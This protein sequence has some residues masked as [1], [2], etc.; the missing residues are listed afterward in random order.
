MEWINIVFLPS[1]KKTDRKMKFEWK[2][3]CALWFNVLY[4]T[5]VCF[6]LALAMSPDQL[7][8]Y[9]L[10]VVIYFDTNDNL[11][12]VHILL[13]MAYPGFKKPNLWLKINMES[14]MQI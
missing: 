9:V 3:N 8:N 11:L 6:E 13:W 7:P 2:R 5:F 10:L 1:R 12:I 14:K 4:W